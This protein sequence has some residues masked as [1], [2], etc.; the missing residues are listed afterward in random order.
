ML[1]SHNKSIISEVSV[2]AL[3]PTIVKVTVDNHFSDRL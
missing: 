3:H 2:L 1:K